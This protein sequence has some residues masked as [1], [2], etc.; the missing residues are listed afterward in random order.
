MTFFEFL[1]GVVLFGSHHAL[2][3]ISLKSGIYSDGGMC[4]VRVYVNQEEGYVSTNDTESEYN[5]TC[6]RSG[7]FDISPGSN[8]GLAR[9]GIAYSK[10]IRLAGDGSFR[11]W[12]RPVEN[13]P[14][15]IIFHLTNLTE[16]KPVTK[17]YSAYESGWLFRPRNE[18]NCYID[19]RGEAPLS[20]SGKLCVIRPK[21]FADISME[22]IEK[23]TR[24]EDALTGSMT[25]ADFQCSHY[26]LEKCKVISR[27]NSYFFDE[28]RSNH[29]FS[30]TRF[31][32]CR[33]EIVLEGEKIK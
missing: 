10:W 29:P 24:C 21:K 27:K 14:D 25:W 8:T 6:S 15:G 17:I 26:S 13:E 3:N 31:T 1:L 22:D 16:E 11:I 9:G 33:A 2:A 20:T 30:P 19:E 7:V 32:G 18:P 28:E 5:V 23:D 12:I 4:T